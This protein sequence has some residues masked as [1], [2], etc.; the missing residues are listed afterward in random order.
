VI[1]PQGP[2]LS[3]VCEPNQKPEFCYLPS[4]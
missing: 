4:P 1:T 2:F 3:I